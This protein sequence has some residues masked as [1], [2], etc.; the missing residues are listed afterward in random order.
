[1]ILFSWIEK[2]KKALTYLAMV[3]A[4]AVFITYLWTGKLVGSLGAVLSILL[5]SFPTYLLVERVFDGGD[6]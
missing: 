3:H 2:S 5:V 4:E 1:M 6:E